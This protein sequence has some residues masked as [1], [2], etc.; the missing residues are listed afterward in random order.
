MSDFEIRNVKASEN[1]AYDCEWNH[2][3]FGWIPFLA[4]ADDSEEHGRKIHA[5]IKAGLHGKIAPYVAPAVDTLKP[6]AISRID[7]DADS[8]YASAVGN[9]AAEYDAAEREAL[10]YAAT[11]Y[12]GQAG[13]LVKS[14]AM[15]KSWT[16]EEAADDIIQKAAEW[17]SAM[18]VIRSQRLISKEAVRIASNK[19]ELDDAMLEW[20]NFVTQ[21]R[22]ALG[23]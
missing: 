14:W 10:A 1:G 2:S 18:S 4:S 13:T 22:G 5:E 16:D 7:S 11:G 19:S 20:D 23:I 6:S 21:T 8:I 15:V 9:R 17:R 3:R 12:T